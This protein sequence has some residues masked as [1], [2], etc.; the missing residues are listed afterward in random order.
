[1]QTIVS[2][3]E[4]AEDPLRGV[5]REYGASSSASRLTPLSSTEFARAASE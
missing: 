5:T 2:N 1:M 3:G 4:N